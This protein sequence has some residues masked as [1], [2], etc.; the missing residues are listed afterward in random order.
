[1]SKWIIEPGAAAGI[2]RLDELAKTLGES[3]RETKAQEQLT[4]E[5]FREAVEAL[6]AQTP[7]ALPPRKSSKKNWA[8]SQR[9]LFDR[10]RKENPELS[11]PE[12]CRLMAESYKHRGKAMSFSKLRSNLGKIGF[13]KS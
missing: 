13:S 10:L 5:R 1:M 12:I 4:Q 2:E 8:G 11:I 3:A 7:A 6:V 9:E